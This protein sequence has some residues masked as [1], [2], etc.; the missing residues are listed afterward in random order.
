MKTLIKRNQSQVDALQD[1][2]ATVLPLLNS[3]WI[4][5]KAAAYYS[6]EHTLAD[7]LNN[8]D[9]IRANYRNKLLEGKDLNIIPGLTL[10]PEKIKSM[11]EVKD[12]SGLV[13]QVDVVK[14]AMRDNVLHLKMF[15]LSNETVVIDDNEVHRKPG[16][17]SCYLQKSQSR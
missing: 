16:S 9:G 1:K 17:V 7:L 14:N 10:D 5:F 12:P 2:L 3:A 11:I 13:N 4:A 6:T 8:L 15:I